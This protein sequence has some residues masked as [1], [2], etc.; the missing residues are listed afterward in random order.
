MK[1]I[2]EGKE[3]IIPNELVVSLR[4]CTVENPCPNHKERFGRGTH[5]HRYFAAYIRGESSLIEVVLTTGETLYID[6]FVN[7]E[8]E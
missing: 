2:V 5:P 8:D 3:V 7:M 4:W 1:A 6:K